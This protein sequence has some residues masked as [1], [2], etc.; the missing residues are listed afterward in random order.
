MSA[1]QS[2]VATNTGVSADTILS[3]RNLEKHFP[4]T[5]G[6]IVQRQVGAV[7]AVDGVSFTRLGRPSAAGPSRSSC[8]VWRCRTQ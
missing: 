4:I 2:A 1:V 5:S 6:L 8:R 3:V 7:R